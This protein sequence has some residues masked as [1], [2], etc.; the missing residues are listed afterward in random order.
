[1]RLLNCICHTGLIVSLIIGC[2]ARHTDDAP[3]PASTAPKVSAAVPKRHQRTV[4]AMGTVFT[5]TIASNA[6]S[7][8]VDVAMNAAFDE[9]RRI[10][11]MMTTHKE[12][13]ALSS[14]NQKAGVGPVKVPGELLALAEKAVEISERTKG[15]FDVTFGAVGKLWRFRDADPHIPSQSDIRN[16]LPLLDY[17]G[18]EIDK[19]A[20]TLM[21]TKPGMSMGL[22]AI[23]KGYG[24]DRAAAILRDKGFNDFIVYGGG[25]IY[26][27]GKKGDTPWRVGI[28]DPRNHGLYFADFPIDKNGA[29][30]TSGD[31]EKFFIKDGKRYHHILDPDTGFPAEGTVSVTVLTEAAADADAMATGIF[32][33]GPDKGMALI[34]SDPKLEGVIVDSDLNVSVSSGLKETISIRPITP[35][36]KGG[37]P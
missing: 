34:E 10:E 31:Y 35:V 22:G 16:R 1:M 5:F 23:A 6:A 2:N 17:H 11:E 15:K 37:L 13:S 8:D 4:S 14:V 9:I 36:S 7:Q 19:Q 25:D 29:V 26:I 3:E 28:Q 27:S 30:V 33:L 32:V 24:V 18:I 21:L 20:S 12:S